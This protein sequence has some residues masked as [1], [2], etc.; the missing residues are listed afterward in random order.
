[1]LIITGQTTLSSSLSRSQSFLS[2]LPTTASG[3]SSGCI[4]L[5]DV[6]LYISVQ[7][8]PLAMHLH[9]GALQTCVHEQDINSSTAS[10]ESRISIISVARAAASPLSWIHP[11]PIGLG[12]SLSISPFTLIIARAPAKVIIKV[13]SHQHWWLAGGYELE[14]GHF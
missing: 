4:L 1:M 13:K 3:S 11:F 9:C 6:S 8:S 2:P 12:I 14:I 5:H 10:G 7:W